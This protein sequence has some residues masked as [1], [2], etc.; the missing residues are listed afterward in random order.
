MFLFSQNNNF[1]LIE[2]SKQNYEII[3]NEIKNLLQSK[4]FQ[5]E[6]IL[7]LESIYDLIEKNSIE[8]AFT[9]SINLIEKIAS[10]FY[11]ISEKYEKF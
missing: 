11:Q 2:K 6:E 1:K 10:N 7:N 3:M 5:E 8:N 9:L 4:I